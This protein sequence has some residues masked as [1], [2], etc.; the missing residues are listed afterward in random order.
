MVVIRSPR[1][2]T[3]DTGNAPRLYSYD[4]LGSANTF[5]GCVNAERRF[6]YFIFIKK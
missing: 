2:D 3:Q 4:Q 1:Q 6:F 5:K